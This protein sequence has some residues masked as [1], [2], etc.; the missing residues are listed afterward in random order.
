MKNGRHVLSLCFVWIIAVILY[1]IYTG[2]FVIPD[3]IRELA[4]IQQDED[5]EFFPDWDELLAINKDTVGYLIIE[6]TGIH[7]PVVQGSDNEHYLYHDFSGE[8]ESAGTL[9]LD[10][11]YRFTEPRSWNSVIYGHSNMRSGEYVPFDDLHA[12]ESEEFYQEHRWIRYDRLPN[13]GDKGLWKIVAVIKVD[14]DFDYR[15]TDFRDEED[16]ER[17]YQAIIDRS[18]Y[19]CGE[20][21]TFGNG[22]L[23]LSTCS[24]PSSNGRLAVVAKKVGEMSN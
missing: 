11:T 22:V 23:T 12:Y 14:K 20:Q 7:T 3:D 16:F 17:Y 8:V 21:V 9:F 24:S 19:D 6:G 4:S 10:N 5:G 2:Q 15:R 18:I 13:L 1:Q